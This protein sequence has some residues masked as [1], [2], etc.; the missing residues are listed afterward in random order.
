MS[1][2]QQ[3]NCCTLRSFQHSQG[4]VFRLPK[5][6]CWS[7]T[8]LKGAS[9]PV[10]HTPPV[11]C[12]QQPRKVLHLYLLLPSLMRSLLGD[13]CLHVVDCSSMCAHD[14]AT[15]YPAAV[16][17]SLQRPKAKYQTLFDYCDGVPRCMHQ[18]FAAG[19]R[20]SKWRATAKK[21][22]DVPLMNQE[23]RGLRSLH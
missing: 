19:H 8:T 13:A 23:L 7:R 3:A 11:G 15:H 5:A 18:P 9:S 16:Y 21:W 2:D 12:V 14:R 10:S 17:L 1:L 6:R 20:S 4:V 22:H